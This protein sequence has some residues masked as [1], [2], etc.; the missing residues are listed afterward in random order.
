VLVAAAIVLAVAT[1]G[2]VA[3]AQ[4]ASQDAD[5]AAAQSATDSPTPEEAARRARLKKIYDVRFDEL[6]YKIKVLISFSNDTRITPRLRA[7]VLRRYRSHAAAFVGDVW[8]LEFEDVSNT[9]AAYHADTI[10]SLP[11]ASLENHAAGRDKLFVLGV[12]FEGDRFVLAARELDVFF[13]RWGPVFSGT[14]RETTQI[15]RELVVLNARMFCPLARMVTSDAKRVT[16][17]MK[18]GKLPTL[19]RDAV[20]PNTSY[21]PSY[22]FLRAPALFRP[23]RTMLNEEGEIT[24]IKPMPWTLYSVERRE[25]SR[26]DCRI[27]S[28]LRVTLPPQSEGP[29]DPEL[30]MARTAGGKTRLR[31]V[32]PENFAPLAALDVEIRDVA[33]GPSFPQ[34]TSDPYGQILLPRDRPSTGLI[35]AVVRHGR[36]T[37]AVLPILPGAGEEPDLALKPDQIRLDV[38]GRVVAVQEQIVDQVARRTILTGSKDRAGN[39]TGGL[40]KKALDKKEWK[41]AADLLKLLKASPTKETMIAKLDNIKEEVNVLLGG[42]K[43]TSKAK[44]MLDDTANIIDIFFNID[45]FLDVVEGFEDDIKNGALEAGVVVDVGPPLASPDSSSAPSAPA[46]STAKAAP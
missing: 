11:A 34:G 13:N 27:I 31:L 2:P 6:A 7:E 33:D 28:A 38:E 10:G 9:L 3:R 40:I 44:R 1:H 45:E 5:A 29:D 17:V 36:D 25:G 46:G 8:Q 23:M 16:I 20:A 19:N 18:G 30:I 12:R 32:D 22:D 35:W 42:K 24:A 15:A 26:A 4:D 43:L 37:L 14:A 41:Q 39:L 21:K